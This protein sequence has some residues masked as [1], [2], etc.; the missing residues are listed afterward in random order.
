MGSGYIIGCSTCDN[1]FRIY[2]GFGF[3]F[4]T[5][6]TFFCNKCFNF[7][8]EPE[9]ETSHKCNNCNE[10]LIRVELI[11]NDEEK[12]KVVDM[13]RRTINWKCKKCGN[14]KLIK[15]P[16]IIMWD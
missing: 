1:E 14:N 4:I 9:N 8:S 13:N 5:M 7:E 11:I 12:V 10:D 3:A 2:E 6:E 16:I 15:K